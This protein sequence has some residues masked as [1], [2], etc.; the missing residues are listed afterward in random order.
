MA[1]RVTSVASRTWCLDRQGFGQC[2]GV[3]KVEAR[4]KPSRLAATIDPA[5]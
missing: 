1:K 5:A 2:L 3:V 4:K